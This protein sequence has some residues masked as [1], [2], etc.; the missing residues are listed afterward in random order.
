MSGSMGGGVVGPAQLH[1]LDSFMH[2]VPPS[3]TSPRSS[4]GGLGGH[5]TMHHAS[6]ASA[7]AATA[8]NQYVGSNATTTTFNNNN[9]NNTVEDRLAYMIQE[10]REQRMRRHQAEMERAAGLD[11][12]I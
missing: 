1:T 2:S 6:N 3:V 12:R 8:P 11:D 4:K 10:K 9:G 5:K 7:A